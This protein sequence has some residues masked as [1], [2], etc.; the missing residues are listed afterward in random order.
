MDYNFPIQSGKFA[1]DFGESFH[2]GSL[3]QVPIIR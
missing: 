3:I 2:G 1:S